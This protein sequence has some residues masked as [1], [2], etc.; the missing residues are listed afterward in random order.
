MKEGREEGMKLLALQVVT[1]ITVLKFLTALIC[2]TEIVLTV[3]IFRTEIVLTVLIFRTEIVFTVFD[4][5][6]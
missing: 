6:H 5:S 4:I 2:F 1:V 3:L